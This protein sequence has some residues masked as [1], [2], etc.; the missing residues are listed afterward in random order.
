MELSHYG[1]PTFYGTRRF[2]TVFT[3]PID[4]SRHTNLYEAPFYQHTY[5]SLFLVVSF[6]LA[7]PPISYT[8][9]STPFMLHALPHL[10]LP[11]LSNQNATCWMHLKND[12]RWEWCIRSEEANFEVDSDQ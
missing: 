2:I 1:E 11:D 6:L 12:K 5:A 8:Y 3:R 4:Q 7:F 10:I 9:F